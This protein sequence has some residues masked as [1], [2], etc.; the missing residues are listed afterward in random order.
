METWPAVRVKEL[1]CPLSA[2]MRVVPRKACLSSQFVG[3]EGFFIS[4]TQPWGEAVERS[5][6]DD[7]LGDHHFIRHLLR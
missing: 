7:G 4:L 2:G 3:T 6:T 5:E 1:E